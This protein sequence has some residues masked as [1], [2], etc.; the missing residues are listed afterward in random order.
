MARK[1]TKFPYADKAYDYDAA[2]LRKAWPRLHRGDCEPLPKDDAVLAA[3]RDFHAGRFAEA[4]DAGLAAGGA[5]RNAAAKAQAVHAH[6]LEKGDKARVALFEE[7]AQWAD[8]RRGEAPKDANAHYLYALA[9]GRYSQGISVAKALSQGLGGKIRDALL[10]A[11]K[12]E[13]KHADAHI[14]YGAY[15]AEVIDKVG[16]IVGG[17]TYGARKESALE[18]FEKAIKLNPESA[19]A[20]IEYANGLILLFGKS[21]LDEATSLYEAAAKHKPADAM[22]RLDVEKAKAELE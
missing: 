18:H 14:A 1:W 5:G 3:W 6:Y 22:E 7:A 16:G 17:V 8:A 9:M 2:G 12:L 11:I 13:P 4:V 21:R 20:R 15:Q 19:I 10:A